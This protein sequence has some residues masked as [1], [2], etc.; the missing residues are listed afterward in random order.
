MNNSTLQNIEFIAVNSTAQIQQVATLAQEIWTKHYTSIIGSE[1]VRYMLDNYQSTSAI[2][3]QIA[4]GMQYF[5]VNLETDTT[6]TVAYFAFKPANKSQELFLSKIY[7][8]PDYQ[9]QGV[10]Q[11]CFSF[12]HS[13]ALGSGCNR[14]RLTVNKNNHKATSAYE[15][16]G[17]VCTGS[18]VTDIGQGFVMDDFEYVLNL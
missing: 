3:S 18:V 14:I 13:Q 10:G 12:I 16:S 9:R 2:T 8:R 5:L 7:V 1:Q 11:A 17:F 4:E 6:E 15:K